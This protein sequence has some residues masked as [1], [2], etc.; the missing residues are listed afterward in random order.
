M[1]DSSPGNRRRRRCVLRA[2][3][4][5]SGTRAPTAG[6]SPGGRRTNL[7]GCH[8]ALMTRL[9]PKPPTAR[10]SRSTTSCAAS[11]SKDSDGPRNWLLP[12]AFSDFKSY[13]LDHRDAS[14]HQVE[15]A[16][17]PLRDWLHETLL[18]PRARQ[19]GLFRP[20]ALERR[21][22][23]EAPWGRAIWAALNLELWHR[24][25]VDDAP[26]ARAEWPAS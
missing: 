15:E 4:P 19:R 14:W 21:I 12:T 13:L 22:D 2:A 11:Q 9:P 16:K 20:D 23:G 17:G 5:L 10:W 6:L 3:L 18:S 24:V 25:F 1:A 7:G 8:E 26:A